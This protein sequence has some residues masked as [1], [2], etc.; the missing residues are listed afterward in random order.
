M[1][2]GLQKLDIEDQKIDIANTNKKRVRKDRIFI[3]VLSIVTAGLFYQT[4]SMA[5]YVFQNKLFN[6]FIYWAM[7]IG[8]VLAV[9]AIMYLINNYRKRIK[10]NSF[11]RNELIKICTDSFLELHGDGNTDETVAEELLKKLG[12]IE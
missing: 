5:V 1:N 11:G 7:L 6:S 10:V 4:A 3:I 9:Y 8:N 12:M 2:Q